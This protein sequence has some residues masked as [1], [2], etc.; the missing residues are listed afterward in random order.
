M[1]KANTWSHTQINK[2][3]KKDHA[4]KL[5]RTQNDRQKRQT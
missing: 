1:K 4:T 2:H 3:K 5:Q